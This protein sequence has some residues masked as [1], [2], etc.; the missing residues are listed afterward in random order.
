MNNVTIPPETPMAPERQRWGRKIPVAIN[1]DEHSKAP[2]RREEET[3]QRVQRT[4]SIITHEPCHP[5][6]QAAFFV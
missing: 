4:P 6:Q 1:E 3:S 2:D 5:K